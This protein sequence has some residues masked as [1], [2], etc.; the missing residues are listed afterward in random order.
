M[1]VSYNGTALVQDVD[2]TVSYANTNP[3][4]YLF[5]G[6]QD[7]PSTTSWA[8]DKYVPPRVKI[9]EHITVNGIGKYY[10]VYK[11]NYTLFL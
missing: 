5:V 8:A 2:Y 11:F 3:S 10:G 4:A 1:T 9:Q 7:Y 6:K